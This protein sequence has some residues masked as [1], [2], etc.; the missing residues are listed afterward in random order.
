VVEFKNIFARRN[1]GILLDVVVFLLNLILL[2]VVTSLAL[3][4]AHQAEENTIA[5]LAVGLY[6]AGLFLLQPLGPILKRWSFHQEARF[7][8][9]S[10]AGCLL[11]WFMFP[12]IVIMLCIS[13]AASIVL[14]EVIFERGSDWANVGIAFIL[15]GF[16]F[17]FVNAGIAYRYFLKPKKEPKW[18]FLMTPQAEVLGDVFMFLNVICFQ[19]LWGCITASELFWESM[20]T[21]VHG[22]SPGLITSTVLRLFAVGALALLVYFP[23]RIFYLAIDR[24]RK[25]TWLT[26]LLAN[27]PLILGVVFFSPAIKLPAITTENP[28]PV[29]RTIF[30]H[31]SVLF[32]AED[33]YR[34]YRLNSV[35]AAKKYQGKYVVVTGRVQSVDLKEDS[36]VGSVV[37]LDGGGKVY[38]VHCYFDADQKETMKQ[39]KEKQKVTLQGIGERFWIGGPVLRHCVLVSSD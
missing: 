38:W 25:I 10:N 2:R 7:A 22:K 24:R 30:G 18:K 28:P 35:A 37:R 39:L 14:S 34:E 3:N 6:F 12:Y 21:T 19:I 11:F 23:P 4:L 29:T 32:T 17:S 36:L 33:L 9:D 5:K 1:R 8:V 20:N 16:V 27:L 15:G 31:T 26:M 13:G